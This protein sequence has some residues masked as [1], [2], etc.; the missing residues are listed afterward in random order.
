MVII[1]NYE[2]E[3]GST[4][5][6]TKPSFSDVGGPTCLDFIETVVYRP[7]K[8]RR[9]FLN[10]YSDLVVW[11]RQEDL[12]TDAEAE[13]LT[14]KATAYPID[15]QAVFDR[16]I[17]LREAIYRIFSAIADGRQ[18]D[19]ADMDI[20]NSEFAGLMA[21]TGIVATEDGFEWDWTH[22]DDTLDRVLWSMVESTANLL[23]SE[24]LD[25]VRQCASS[26]CSS[27]F[28]DTS[29]NRRRRWCEMKTC[30]NRAKARRHYQ[31]KKQ[32]AS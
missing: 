10:S 25:R 28:L 3:S 23:T 13:H 29:K 6:D 16:A 26:D 20:F 18:P 2:G 11:S 12:I 7:S 24:Q 21:K 32:V 22:E 19:R 27:L 4:T 5:E 9:E 14:E 31:R 1:G 17:A 30:G 8:R 15:A